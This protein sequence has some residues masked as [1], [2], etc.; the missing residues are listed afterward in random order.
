M[1]L[2]KRVDPQAGMD[3][4]Y[5]A[6]AVRDV[7]GDSAILCAWGNRRN[8]YQRMH[9]IYPPATEVAQ[10]ITRIVAHKVKRGYSIVE[11]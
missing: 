10:N 2:L 9:L 7:F 8:C 5:L 1:T 11:E 6:G 3:R 4:W